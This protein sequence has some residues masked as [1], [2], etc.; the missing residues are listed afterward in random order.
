MQNPQSRVALIRKI[1]PDPRPPR[2]RPTAPCPPESMT[3][4]SPAQEDEFQRRLTAVGTRLRDLAPRRLDGLTDPDPATGERWDAGQVWAHI[5]EFVPYWIAQAE[6]VLA[7]ESADPVPFGRTRTSPERVAAIERDRHRGTTPLWHDIR[8]DLN[9]L[10][11]F[12][13]EIPEHR[14]RV[15][16]LHPTLGV[17]PISQ[18]VEELLIGHL[19]EHAAQLEHLRPA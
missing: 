8:E 14:W 11:A 7:S 13:G 3:P 10:H 6:R 4:A 18:I 1:G 17:M 2:E 16:G 9:D 12:L 5:A 19:E 15:R